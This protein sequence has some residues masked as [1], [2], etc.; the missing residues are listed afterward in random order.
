M[1][2]AR[3]RTIAATASRQSTATAVPA[4]G[5][6]GAGRRCRRAACSRADSPTMANETSTTT[7]TA[8][9]SETIP[10]RP[11]APQ[12]IIFV[13]P[14]QASA[15]TGVGAGTSLTLSAVTGRRR[16]AA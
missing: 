5:A 6:D 7:A 8:T 3:S 11:S 15:P 2:Q 12:L 4:V 16:D 13:L 9:A 10:T 14:A 1:I